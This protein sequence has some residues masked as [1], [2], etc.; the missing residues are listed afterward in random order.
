MYVITTDVCLRFDSV[1]VSAYYVSV[2]FPMH[3][4]FYRAV[5][6]LDN[7]DSAYIYVKFS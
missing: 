3:F 6:L 5:A 2:P 7:P 1:L 4:D